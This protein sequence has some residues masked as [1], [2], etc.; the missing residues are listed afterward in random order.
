MPKCSFYEND[1]R[2]HLQTHVRKKK[3]ADEGLNRLVSIVATSKRQRGKVEKQ[4]ASKKPKPGR[5]KKWCPMPGCNK[6]ILNVGRHLTE[7]KSHGLKKGSAEYNE[8]M[9]SAK[10]Y[11]GLG[12]IEAYLEPPASESHSNS[13]SELETT[14]KPSRKRRKVAVP[15]DTEAEA[16]KNS[17]DHEEDGKG[18]DERG[19]GLGLDDGGHEGGDEEEED[20]AG[21]DDEEEDDAEKDDDE[22][23]SDTDC[24]QTRVTSEEYFTGRT[25]KNNRHRWL[26]GFY[27]YLS[28]PS[29]GNKKDTI[30]LQ[31]ASQMRALL[32]HLEPGGDDITCL[33]QNEGDA[34]WQWWVS[35]MIDQKQN[36]PGTVISY[37]T[38]SEKFS[39]FVTNLRYSRFGPPLGPDYQELFQIVLPEVKGW[40]STVD[41]QTQDVQNQRFLDETEGLL[42]AQE[43][44]TLTSSKPFTEGERILKQASLGKELP[45]RS[46]LPQ[47]TCLL[48]VWG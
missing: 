8:M 9:K 46:L 10:K 34:V 47:E 40:R 30:R 21:E 11:T 38:S 32:E 16:E 6:V 19:D 44:L 4:G 14:K 42:T 25:Y 12:D 17:E 45:S 29:A 7:G 33:V 18:G 26:V 23:S 37:L 24:H 2:R 39:M 27:D 35:P 13:D 36:K 28:R 15:S 20:D 5:F 31:H 41:S 48:H 43:L 3:L 22:D 1:L